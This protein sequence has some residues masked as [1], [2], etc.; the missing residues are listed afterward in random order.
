MKPQLNR[1]QP[2]A[3]IFL[4]LEDKMKV[5]E[6]HSRGRSIISIA[7]EFHVGTT[8]VR[9]IIQKKLI[10]R[11]EWNSGASAMRRVTKTRTSDFQSINDATYQWFL[12]ARQKNVP[13]TGS[14][15]KQKAKQMADEFGMKDFCAS[16]GWLYKFQRRRNITSRLLSGESAGICE[17]TT[18]EWMNKIPQICQGYQLGEIFN[19]DETGLFF[20]AP[21]RRSLV[22]KGDTCFGVKRSKERVTVVLCCSAVGEKLPP[23]IVGRYKKPRC[24]KRVDISKIGIDYEANRRSWMT[25]GNFERWLR[26]VNNRMFKERRKILLFLDNCP[27]HPPMELSNMKLVFLPPN[28]TSRLQPLDA[29]II[30]A[31]KMHYRRNLL[32]YI[33]V[34]WDQPNFEPGFSKV[35]SPF[36]ISTDYVQIS[37]L[38]ALVWIKEAWEEVSITTI[39]NCFRTCGIG[40]L[41]GSSS[42]EA[43]PT[44]ACE[45]IDLDEWLGEGT[46]EDYATIGMLHLPL[47]NL[48]LDESIDVFEDS[49][50]DEE[51]NTKS[52]NQENDIEFEDP[53]ITLD[54]ALSQADMLRK[55]AQQTD[56]DLLP[57]IQEI[58]KKLRNLR[59]CNANKQTVLDDFFSK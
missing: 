20:R 10:I 38:D 52:S 47:P 15:L 44:S 40:P 54:E 9:S 41:M 3:R 24:F 19:M 34:R 18:T 31:F 51:N 37:L 57:Y 58:T 59:V 53:T 45:V 32:S 26:G 11:N 25:S 30:K 36:R 55:F 21:P 16:N 35:S 12:N 14:M 5:I 1:K 50:S 46:L 4:P 2:A 42:P 39:S 8:Q 17:R 48:F 23:L 43:I 49:P 56:W 7:E 6:M 29:G 28:T 13:I 27:A 22:E 33:T